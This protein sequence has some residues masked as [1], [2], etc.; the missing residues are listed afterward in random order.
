[1]K[2]KKVNHILFLLILSFISLVTLEYIFIF[3]IDKHRGYHKSHRKKL[4][5]SSS[6]YSQI[7]RRRVNK[8]DI[9]SNRLDDDDDDNDGIIIA[10]DS[11]GIKVTNRGFQ[12]MKEEKWQVANK[13]GYLTIHM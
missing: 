5:R 7:C 10:I 12:W 3:H 4:T 9:T 6:S 2:I 1:M 11:T 13:K 8:L